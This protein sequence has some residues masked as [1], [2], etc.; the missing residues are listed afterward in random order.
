MFPAWEL[1]VEM[2]ILSRVDHIFPDK[3]E[4]N[5]KK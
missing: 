5:K 3:A 4:F 1:L 2:H